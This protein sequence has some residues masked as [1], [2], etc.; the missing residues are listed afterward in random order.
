MAG[1][2]DNGEVSQL[3]EHRHCGEVECVSCV[4]LEGSHAALAENYIFVAACH[5]VF[6]AHEKLFQCVCKTAL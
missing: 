4:S 1:V 3:V 2:N 5:D 6:R